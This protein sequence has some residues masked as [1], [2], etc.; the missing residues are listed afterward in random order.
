MTR[1]TIRANGTGP[2]LTTPVH[3]MVLMDGEVVA[4]MGTQEQATEWVAK[5]VKRRAFCLRNWEVDA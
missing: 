1:Y 4:I 3:Y 5:E 2:R